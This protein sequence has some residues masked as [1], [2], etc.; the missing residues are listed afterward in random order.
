MKEA[1]SSLKPSEFSRTAKW[2][3]PSLVS[4][5]PSGDPSM[6]EWIEA[7]LPQGTTLDLPVTTSVG[8]SMRGLTSRQSCRK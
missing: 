2:R 1:T 6:T 8:R 4:K 3:P 5:I 7:W